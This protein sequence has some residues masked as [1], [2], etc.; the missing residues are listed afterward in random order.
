MKLRNISLGNLKRKKSKM[1]FLIV[2]MA[3]GIATVVSI[4]TITQAMHDDIQKKLDE[5]G[6]NIMVLPKSDTLS[7]TYGG[8]SISG[9]NYDIREISED[10]VDKIWDI[11]NSGNLTVVSPKLLGAVDVGDD[12][13]LVVGA[14][15][16]SEIALK[17]WW[18]F[19][20]ESNIEL[21]RIE[22][23]SPI[24]PEKTT[25]VTEIEDFG[26]NDVLI[27]TAVAEKLGKNP[28]EKV[29]LNGQLF[30]IKGVLKQTGSQD[31]SIIFMNLEAAQSLLDKEGKITLVE[32]AAIC[33]GCPVEV[34]AAQINEAIPSGHATPIKQVVSQ[35]MATIDRVNSFGMAVGI[36]V[37][38]IGSMIVFTTMM[39]SVNERTREI[40]IFRAIGFR[41]T[42]IVKVIM[43]EAFVLSVIAG[44]IG[45]GIGMGITLTAGTEI[46][47]IETSISIDPYFAGAALALSVFV[48]TFATIYPALKASRIDPSDALRHI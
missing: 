9:A 4:F 46:A 37:L 24:D 20:D 45:Y 14:D 25:V 41:R 19:T 31:D 12:E 2:G 35:R 42:H 5:Y 38:I 17:K 44:I 22:K 43:M 7:M 27:G 16:T 18:E 34:M 36:V 39:S 33:S 47:E 26:N 15:M 6:A 1:V 23:P 10:E 3:I 29:T 40:G 11:R 32:V 30:N 8:I 21:T 48:G 28:N 13:I